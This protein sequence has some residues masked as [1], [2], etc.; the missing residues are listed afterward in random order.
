LNENGQTALHIAAAADNE[1]AVRVLLD[2]GA[3][4]AKHDNNGKT[5]LMLAEW[6][7]RPLLIE[8][9][10][11]IEPTDGAILLHHATYHREDV[12]LNI[13]LRKGVDANA[14]RDNLKSPLFSLAYWWDSAASWQRSAS[15][16]CRW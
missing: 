12:L 10:A 3:D 2:G 13:L 7:T 1:A 9:T 11:V 5:P 15:L 8:R 4:P 14:S 16:K 6:K